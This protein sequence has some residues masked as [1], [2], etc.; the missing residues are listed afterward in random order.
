MSAN[1]LAAQFELEHLLVN[2]LIFSPGVGLPVA[3]NP[4]LSLPDQKRQELIGKTTLDKGISRFASKLRL[5]GK[6]GD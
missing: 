5:T 4:P 2:H 3:Q 1:R 6:N